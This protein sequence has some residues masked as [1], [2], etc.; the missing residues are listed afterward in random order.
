MRTPSLLTQA[1]GQV[2]EVVLP[3]GL[4]VLMKEAHTSPLVSA[5]C[6]YRVGSKDEAPGHTGISHWVEHMNFKGSQNFR[7]EEV[8]G[9]IERKG[10]SWNGYTWID[11][12]CYLSTLSRDGLDLILRLEADRMARC[13]YDEDEIGS[14]RTVIISELEGGENNP[15]EVLDR[16]VC[17]A[18]FRVHP[19]SWPTIGWLTDLKQITPDQLRQHYRTYY[20]PNNATL[21]LV[22]DFDTPEALDWVEKHFGSIPRGEEPRRVGTE[23]PPQVGER[24]VRVERQGEATYLQISYHAPSAKAADAHAYLLLDAI[25]SGGKGP[26]IWSGEFDRTRKSSRLYRRLVDGGL[27]VRV[28]SFY[29]PAEHPYLHTFL[30]TVKEGVEP[31]EVEKVLDEEIQLLLSDGASDREFQ[32]ALNQVRAA[33]VLGADS[34]TKL[35]HELGYFET[36]HNH[37]WYLDLI[38]AI[39]KVTKEDVLRVARKHLVPENRTVGISLP[40]RGKGRSEAAPQGAGKAGGAPYRR[41]ARF[42][43]SGGPARGSSSASP[44]PEATA[45]G[46]GIT[47]S[48]SVLQS[49]VVAILQENHL[50]PA[51]TISL[52][53]RA[54]S[55]LD[56]AGKIGSAYLVARLLD[57]GTRSRSK[58]EIAGTIDFSGAALSISTDSHVIDVQVNVL[59]DDFPTILSLVSELVQEPVFPVSEL[60]TMRGRVLMAIREERDDTKAEADR[61]L[62]EAIYPEGH[63]YRQPVLGFEPD[64]R[65]ITRDDLVAFHAGAFL[66]KSATLV[67]V[68]DFESGEVTQRVQEAF[69]GW[70]GLQESPPHSVPEVPWREEASETIITMKNKSQADIALGCRG[71]ARHD[72]QYHPASL[73]NFVLGRFGMGGR[74]GRNIREEQG[75]AYYAFSSFSPSLGPGPFAVHVGANPG[76]IEKAV[77]AIL[78]ELK[79]IQEKG[80]TEEELQEVKDYLTGSLPRALETNSGIASQIQAMEFF[81]LGLDYLDR[82]PD[83]VRAVTPEQ[84]LEA[85]RTQIDTR[86][87]ALSIAGPWEGS[88]LRK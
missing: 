26:S 46:T 88:V 74:L 73:M 18:A 9:L 59:K 44:S 10:G 37:Q 23:E 16:E 15:E 41:G 75:L 64:V 45:P 24:R 2:T 66:P 25:L 32:M 50:T 3:N 27:A 17:A 85:A 5:W 49:G 13:L 36:I 48:R 57:A 63:P 7:K 79:G 1:S 81:E 35:A 43:P 39:E 14:E 60:E 71:I 20:V 65:G 68:G 29:V 8:K 67:L 11:Q 51:V 72:P 42:A 61:G 21:V 47:P 33:V 78:A 82:Y 83:L 56:V 12:T 84:A 52:R 22:G 87:F 4:K 40:S 69:G 80:V 34:V 58:A 6:W 86:G 28:G 31:I 53:I 19:Y 30:A 70:K 62:R 76:H 54:G 55:A 38:P 77:K